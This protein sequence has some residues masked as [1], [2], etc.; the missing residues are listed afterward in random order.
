[1]FTINRVFII[2]KFDGVKNNNKFIEKSIKSK[3]RKLSKLWN[4]A[5]SEKKVVKK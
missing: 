3:S 2:N 1:M 4:S 5:K